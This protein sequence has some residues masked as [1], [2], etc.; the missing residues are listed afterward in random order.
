MA[1]NLP[2][3]PTKSV[4]TGGTST[5]ICGA[6]GLLS[7]LKF[8][9][10]HRY[11]T[12]TNEMVNSPMLMRLHLSRCVRRLFS[13]RLNRK[14]SKLLSLAMI[15]FSLLQFWCGFLAVFDLF[16]GTTVDV[17]SLIAAVEPLAVAAVGTGVDD[18]NSNGC[19]ALSSF[20]S[21]FSLSLS[22]YGMFVDPIF[23]A[24]KSIFSK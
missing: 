5:I 18:C 7:T 3:V 15:R 17:G 10:T 2:L 8:N 9:E 12:L 14:F 11:I 1:L 20:A 13:I 22:E 19:V 16:I 4:S 24:A 21:S 23:Q 6:G